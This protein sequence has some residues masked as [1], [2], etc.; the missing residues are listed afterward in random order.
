MVS[1]NLIPLK[2]ERI[3]FMLW[4]L[5]LLKS[6]TVPFILSRQYKMSEKFERVIIDLVNLCFKASFVSDLRHFWNINNPLMRSNICLQL[7]PQEIGYFWKDYFVISNNPVQKIQIITHVNCQKSDVT[8]SNKK[9]SMV[10]I[11]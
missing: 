4:K 10:I 11:L 1:F 9:L 2:K 7:F 6:T 3:L 5:Y 8:S